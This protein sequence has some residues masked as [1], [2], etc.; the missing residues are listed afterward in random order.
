MKPETKALLAKAH[1][2]LQAG[3]L[4]SRGGYP[5]FAA[6]RAYY[7]MLYAAQ[8]LLLERGLSFSKHTAVIGAF[9]REFAKS[10]SLDVKY[11]RYLIDA[12][13]FRNLGDYG[14][15][16]E[17]TACQAETI[18]EWA[19]EFLAAAQTRIE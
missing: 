19:A 16:P 4:L 2:S 10:G 17:L 3:K 7:A 13:D 1:D 18:I 12:Q 11:H 14:V 6:S 8:A 9:G 5:D 15:G